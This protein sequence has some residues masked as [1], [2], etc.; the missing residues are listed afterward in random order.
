MLGSQSSP[1]TGVK[2]EIREGQFQGG[3]ICNEWKHILPKWGHQGV[4]LDFPREG[5]SISWMGIGPGL[6]NLCLLGLR[7]AFLCMRTPED[8]FR[9]GSLLSMLQEYQN[10]HICQ[11]SPAPDDHFGH[12]GYLPKF[13]WGPGCQIYQNSSNWQDFTSILTTSH[14]KVE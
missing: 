11:S 5:G 3:R 14:W 9:L 7:M 8:H 10:L 13:W 1:E 12:L 4:E 2:G 6:L